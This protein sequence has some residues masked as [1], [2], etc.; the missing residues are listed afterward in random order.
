MILY[1]VG[2]SNR[3]LDELIELLLEYKIGLLVD[4]RRWPK[5]RKFP[6]FNKENLEKQPIE[7][8][9]LEELGGYRKFGKDVNDLGIAK[10]FQSEG[11]RAYA[12]YIT[13][14]EKA[15]NALDNLLKLASTR[16][17]AIMC[18]ERLPWN[19]HRKI[20]SDW[21]YA[22]GFKVI[23]IIDKEH[24]IEHKLSKCASIRDNQ[25]IYF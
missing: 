16:N 23:H 21:F 13:T 25:L 20:I 7:Y 10:C 19:C 4:V 24:I 11:F 18:A 17:V 8:I 14:S 12:T 5:S 9:W 22:K 2:H 6:H 3:T 15:K 1:T